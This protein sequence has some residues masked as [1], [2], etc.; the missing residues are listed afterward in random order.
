[1]VTGFCGWWKAGAGYHRGRNVDRCPYLVP[2]QIP[3]KCEL[4]DVIHNPLPPL[5]AACN[6]PK[7]QLG[8][9]HFAKFGNFTKLPRCKSNHSNN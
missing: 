4:R 3:A 9:E 8:F 1:M 7:S 2:E 5:H 6:W